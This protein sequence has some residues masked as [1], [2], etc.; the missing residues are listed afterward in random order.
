MNGTEEECFRSRIV[1]QQKYVLASVDGKST[2]MRLMRQHNMLRQRRRD[3]KNGS[4]IFGVVCSHEL[5]TEVDDKFNSNLIGK[6]SI[7]TIKSK[8]GEFD[9]ADTD[10]LIDLPHATGSADFVEEYDRYVDCKA[11]INTKNEICNNGKFDDMDIEKCDASEIQLTESD[12]GQNCDFIADDTQEHSSQ[13][14]F[15]NFMTDLR[16]AD[17]DSQRKILTDQNS[18]QRQNKI[19]KFV[20][21][22]QSQNSHHSSF[23]KNKEKKDKD[24]IMSKFE[25]KRSLRDLVAQ[26]AVDNDLRDYVSKPYRRISSYS[27]YCHVCALPSKNDLRFQIFYH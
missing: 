4:T 10:I 6:N 9:S 23:T 21:L 14:N 26:I 13:P 24:R 25:Q 2:K 22:S 3:R 16:A 5:V 11:R 1:N 12:N 27:R 7:D 8:L 18:F 19:T 17:F 20:T 15:Q